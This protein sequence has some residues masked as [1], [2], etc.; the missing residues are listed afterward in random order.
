[1]HLHSRESRHRGL[2]AWGVVLVLLAGAGVVGATPAH[3]ADT[4]PPRP[5]TQVV[6]TPGNGRVTLAWQNP[7]SPDLVGVLVVRAQGTAAPKRSTGQQ[8]AR[9]AGKRTFVD[10]LLESATTY[11]YALFAYD[12]SGNYATSAVATAT[13]SAVVPSVATLCGDLT[14][15]VR[16]SARMAGLILMTCPVTVPAGLTLTLAPGARVKLSGGVRV[17]GTLTSAAPVSGIPDPRIT[18][19]WDDSVGG[20]TDR[21]TSPPSD[22]PVVIDL[23]PGG[24]VALADTDFRWTTLRNYDATDVAHPARL[25][26]TATTW[27][28]SDIDVR[29]GPVGTDPVVITGNRFERSTVVLGN[30]KRPVVRDN[31]FVDGKGVGYG[32]VVDAPF[33]AIQIADLSGIGANTASGARPGQ[34]VLAFG[35]S[36]VAKTWQMARTDAIY[37]LDDITVAAGATLTLTPGVR[38]KAGGSGVMFRVAGTLNT[39]ATVSG[40][41]NPVLTSGWDDSLG[42]DTDGTEQEPAAN[43]AKIYPQP[44]GTVAL[45]NTELRWTTLSNY[46]ATDVAGPATV[47]LVSNVW[48]DSDIDVRYG[49][50]GTDPVVITG[51]R[52]ERSTVVLGN[53][54]R[55]V[56]RDNAFVDGKGVGYGYVVDAPFYAS[57]IAN[58]SGIGANTATGTRPGQKVMAI[59][60]SSVTGAWT[61]RPGVSYALDDV[62]VAAGGSLV[63]LSGTSMRNTG[64]VTV[65]AGGTLTMSGTSVRSG[66]DGDQW[67][68][69]T[70]M[71]GSTT[72]IT[73]STIS[74]A[75]VAIDAA[76][77]WFV[78]GG[79]DVTVATSSFSGNGFDIR[80]GLSDY[81]GN[82]VV[83]ASSSTVPK[84]S[85]HVHT[86]EPPTVDPPLSP[87]SRRIADVVSRGVADDPECLPGYTEVKGHP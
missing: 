43:L 75:V 86:C 25:S 15:S 31:A 10:T 82:N 12:T 21:S 73:D 53:L 68:G 51:N 26:L 54:K 83:D 16:L 70:L 7:T 49:P 18:S 32:Y 69:F 34:K 61:L 62:T 81:P 60:T 57:Q 30:L 39:S 59:S 38:I 77:D 72:S 17:A 5:V 22:N 20:D 6:A 78:N 58:L 65:V 23:E 47:N 19:G 84:G 48:R 63:A 87:Y 44:G 8:V 67:P 71:A 56:V 36:T 74:G 79:A 45:S 66:R 64:P 76:P 14:T 42:G 52:F 9:V 27:R 35:T 28:D 40:T 3:A 4:T 55:P 1:M 13:T 50:V 85:I 41:P 11:S 80:N 2:L 37:A 33:Y 24:N 29:Y 46:D